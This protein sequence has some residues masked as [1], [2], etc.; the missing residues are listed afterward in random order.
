[1]FLVLSLPDGVDGALFLSLEHHRRRT[2]RADSRCSPPAVTSPWGPWTGWATSCPQP[3]SV[4]SHV[5]LKV[6]GCSRRVCIGPPDP[7]AL[8][9]SLQDPW[10]GSRTGRLSGGAYTDWDGSRTGSPRAGQE[11]LELQNGIQHGVQRKH[12]F[13]MQERESCLK[14]PR[15]EISLSDL[16]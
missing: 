2:G 15:F 11:S 13:D 14:E 8:L 12:C 7:R 16:D 1:M 10:P 3:C 4:S 9:P 5:L 6:T